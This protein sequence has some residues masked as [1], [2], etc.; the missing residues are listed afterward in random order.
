MAPNYLM[1]PKLLTLFSLLSVLM[2]SP[3]S[4]AFA[5]EEGAVDALTDIRER[6]NLRVAVYREHPPFSYNDNGRL[7]GLDVELGELIAKELGVF[8]NPMVVNAS[9]EAMGDDLRNNVWRGH[10][11][12]GGVADV[13]MHVPIDPQLAE[14]NRQVSLFA[15][16]LTQRIVLL[17]DTEAT[18]DIVD[19]TSVGPVKIGV[20]MAS[21]GSQFFL[22]Y[23]NG[24]L[25]NQVSHFRTVDQL[26]DA[27]HGG[28]VNLLVVTEGQAI[29]C[30]R[31]AKRMA[32]EPF[33]E[34]KPRLFQWPIGLAV[35]TD[36]PELKTAL[37]EIMQRL[38]N[39]GK[40]AEL[41]QRYGFQ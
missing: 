8:F 9:D 34:P 38:D 22:R 27:I 14:E 17:R 36:H 18:T 32:I 31:K 11:M 23:D 37:E 40:I 28:E 26:C 5:Q 39:T 2:G 4:T 24:R 20:E 3:V 10:Y 30:A 19:W 13:M 16:Y 33:P 29:Y 21:I 1:Q 41:R 12:G 7:T 25:I 15:P 6:G 35:K